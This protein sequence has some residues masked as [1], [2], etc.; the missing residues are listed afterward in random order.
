MP[1]Y[2]LMASVNWI[3]NSNTENGEYEFDTEEDAHK[4]AWEAAIEQVDTWVELVEDDD[5]K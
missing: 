1:K 4:E 2:R 3:A 5:N